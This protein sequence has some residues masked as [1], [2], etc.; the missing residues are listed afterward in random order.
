MQDKRALY[1]TSFSGCIC[2]RLGPELINFTEPGKNIIYRTTSMYFYRLNHLLFLLI[3]TTF[4][5]VACAGVSPASDSSTASSS[6]V[7]DTESLEWG[8]GV[9]RVNITPEEPMWMAGYGFRD[10]PSEGVRQELWA[11]AV[12][13]EDA[14]GNLS[15]L[16]T[17]DLLG[18]PKG[19]SDTIRDRLE[20]EYGL[21]RAQI[22]LNSSHTHTGPVLED[23]LVDIY[24]LDD[25]QNSLISQYSRQLEDDIV[26]LVGE[27]LESI[28]P[29][30]LYAENGVTR[31]AVNRRN[32]PAATLHQQTEL[33]G[34]SDHAVP[35]IKVEDGSGDLKAVVFGYACH[36][37][38]LN[39]YH[40]SGDYAG[41]SQLE[42]E[43]KYPGV[44]ALFFQGAGADQ[45][46]LPRGTVELGEQNGLNLAIAVDRV[47]KEEMRPLRSQLSTAYSEVDINLSPLPSR[48]EMAQTRDES[49]GYSR[50]WAERML[51]IMDSGE[52]FDTTYPYPVQVW[53]IGDQP[54]FTLGGELVVDYAIEIKRIFGFESFVMGY[55]NDVMAYIPSAR[56]IREGGYEGFTAQRVYGLPTTWATDI[57]TLILAEVLKVAEQAG[58]KAK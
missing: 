22:I 3:L 21:N 40:W 18:I 57:E 44:T 15:V 25:H 31:F 24:P 36:T 55:T 10:H 13:L 37:T 49:S 1:A 5:G 52:S 26:N 46:P 34:P 53:M 43:K 19:I 12:A 30:R 17:S 39:D 20:E 9:A 58:L 27:A 14:T 42:L 50:R 51:G 16:V 54:L 28:E 2:S 33:Q 23:A 47:L 29:A 4:A 56:I 32:N 48:E 41:F 38:A 7:T 8:A 35:V 45:N 6:T 11:K